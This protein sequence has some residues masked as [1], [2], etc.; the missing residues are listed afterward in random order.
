M[1]LSGVH[2]MSDKI[3]ENRKNRRAHE[4]YRDEASKVIEK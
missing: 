4:S 1:K 2:L 3:R